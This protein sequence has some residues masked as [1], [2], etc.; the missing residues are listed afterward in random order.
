MAPPLISSHPL[1]THS[2]CDHPGHG[3]EDTLV[4]ATI[5]HDLI[6]FLTV[7]PISVNIHA[8][9]KKKWIIK[10]ST[11]VK[12]LFTYKSASLNF[13]FLSQMHNFCFLYLRSY[14]WL[15][16]SSSISRI[17][18]KQAEKLKSCKM[19]EWW[20]KNDE[21]WMMKLG[22]ESSWHFHNFL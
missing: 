22:G 13:Y 2:V 17:K 16:S 10:I 20:M 19:K 15:S 5:L 3:N 12:S 1:N 18:C 4:L 6:N 8:N 7:Y 9:T 14:I 11:R 21:G